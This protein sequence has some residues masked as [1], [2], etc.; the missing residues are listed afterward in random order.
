[1]RVLNA[2]LG[3]FDKSKFL[4]Q[5]L[6]L[7]T[8]LFSDFSKR[9]IITN[10]G[11]N[12]TSPQFNNSGSTGFNMTTELSYDFDFYN[13][14]NII[15]SFK[16]SGFPRVQQYF[17][18]ILSAPIGTES[19]I[20]LG[21]R[22]N[23]TGSIGINYTDPAYYDDNSLGSVTA[24]V[25][26]ICSIIK[27]GSNVRVFIDDNLYLNFS[28]SPSRTPKRLILSRADST[29]S[30]YG[31]IGNTYFSRVAKLANLNFDS[32]PFTDST[33]RNFVSNVGVTQDTNRAYFNNPTDSSK[34]YLVINSSGTFNN[35]NLQNNFEVVFDITIPT[36]A[37]KGDHCFFSIQDTAMYNG[38]DFVQCYVKNTGQIWLNFP[39]TAPMTSATGVIVAGNTYTIRV[40]K[41][42]A[43]GELWVGNIKRASTSSI[44]S[45]TDKPRVIVL[46]S[47]P[48]T[49]VNGGGING[50]M[51]NFQFLSY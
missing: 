26:Y 48:N 43:Q 15:T 51:D 50:Y 32:F 31:D 29:S 11:V 12:A 23:D 17:L 24:G 18:T 7:N 40:V 6:S 13:D 3:V 37:G 38:T 27:R 10:T 45:I 30:F 39:G 8:S 35:F 49:L 22:V 4:G 42:G 1:M 16:V 25:S 36:F 9:H 47:I 33:G 5:L 46:G 20:A 2:P 44:P 14:F 28:A 21:L 34:N 41:N 19:G